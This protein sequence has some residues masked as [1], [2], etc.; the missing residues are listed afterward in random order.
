MV[1]VRSPG[2]D[3]GHSIRR[4]SVATPALARHERS[5]A[6]RSLGRRTRRDALPEHTPYADTGCDLH[7]SCLTCPFVRCRYDED[8]DAGRRR[9]GR[10]RDRRMIELQRRGKTISVIAARFGVSR[11]TVFRVLARARSTVD[12]E[13]TSG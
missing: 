5:L 4:R 12:G 6:E 10:Q 11:R 3:P 1:A 7:A 9:A 2:Q 8:L 13:R